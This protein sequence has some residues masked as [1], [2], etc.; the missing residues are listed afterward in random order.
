MACYQHGTGNVPPRT[1]ENFYVLLW[2]STSGSY[3]DGNNQLRRAGGKVFGVNVGDQWNCYAPS[4]QGIA[5]KDG[6][7]NTWAELIGDNLYVLVP[8]NAQHMA[9]RLEAFRL[10]IDE[11]I[12]QLETD[13][14]KRA[15]LVAKMAKRLEQERAQRTREGLKNLVTQLHRKTTEDLKQKQDNDQFRLEQISSETIQIATRMRVNQIQLRALEDTLPDVEK[16]AAKLFKKLCDVDK[17]DGLEV[18]GS[19]LK[20]ST[21][22]LCATDART[23][24]SHEIGKMLITIDITSG[25]VRFLNQTR[26]V[27]AYW[28]EANAPHVDGNGTACLGNAAQTIQQLFA[29][30]DLQTLVVFL[31]GFVES[32]N[33]SD[34]AGAYITR[35]PLAKNVGK[36]A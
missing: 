15:E 7:N 35:W 21:A 12:N 4:G 25:K 8:I 6:Q 22:L 1:D 17:V 19:L 16:E 14:E 32:V 30:M 28:P 26:K 18:D 24:L 36:V 20:I 27:E 5:I 3:T 23:G 9:N 10:I 33:I 34:R 2:S 31:I 29:T 13:P 11:T